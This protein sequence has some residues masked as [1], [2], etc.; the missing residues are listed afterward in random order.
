MYLANG[1]GN[2]V[3]VPNPKMADVGHLENMFFKI[4]VYS[5]N[6]HMLSGVLGIKEFI[7]DVNFII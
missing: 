2:F 7:F 1:W 5:A 6:Q 3:G 4:L